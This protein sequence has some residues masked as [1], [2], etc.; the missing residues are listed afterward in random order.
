MTGEKIFSNVL[1]TAIA[2]GI[3]W[4]AASLTDVITL[5][6]LHEYRITELEEWR[7]EK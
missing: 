7:K 5:V 2:A 3:L 4:A 1:Q 6:E